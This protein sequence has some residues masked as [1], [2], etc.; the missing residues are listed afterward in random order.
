[1]T[2]LLARLLAMRDLI[3]IVA[4]LVMVAIA[5]RWLFGG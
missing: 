5:A 1:M 4:I 2:L 3:R